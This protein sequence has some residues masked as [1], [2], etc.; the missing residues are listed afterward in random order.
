[1]TRKRNVYA[2]KMALMAAGA[3]VIAL[4]YARASQ[5]NKKQEKSVG[6]QLD[7]GKGEAKQNRWTVGK[8]FYD[9][10]ISASKYARG[11]KRPDYELLLEAIESGEGDVLILFELARSNR[12]LMIYVNLREL[13]IR[14][15]LYF[16]LIGGQLYDLRVR[17]DLM[18]LGFQA[19]QAEDQ[20]VATHENVKRGKAGSALRGLPAGKLNYGYTRVYDGET[21]A[22]VKQIPDVEIRE[23]VSDDGKVS[24]YTRAGIIRFVFE[25]LDEGKSIHS[26]EKSIFDRGIRSRKGNR[27]GRAVIRKWALNPVYIGKRVHLT[28]TVGAGQ[29]DGLVSDELYWSVN[30]LLNDVKRTKTR[31]GSGK[32]LASWIGKCAEDGSPISVTPPSEHSYKEHVY[33]CYRKNCWTIPMVELDS[34]ILSTVIAWCSRPDIEELLTAAYTANDEALSE[35]RA[36]AKR[37]ESEWESWMKDATAQRLKPSVVARFE[38]Q[39][40]MDLQAARDRASELS[41]PS[42]LRDSIGPDAERKIMSADIEVKRELI[43]L[44]GPF[45]VTRALRKDN[46]PLTDR[47]N[48]LGLLGSEF[49]DDGPKL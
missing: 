27:I 5:D 41:L 8:V 49:S 39:F 9:N 26:I 7:L 47:V 14:V 18:S 28:E 17:A 11:K 36:E 13:C 24:K 2:N 16:W 15:G 48:W 29:W 12:D 40:E 44:L 34:F 19:V 23:A 21:G 25:S 22:F 4:I 33:R 32:Y 35:A 46:V 42:V 10:N 31:P 43:R 1:M 45:E 3:R 37:I 6:D 30:V 38:A 20:S